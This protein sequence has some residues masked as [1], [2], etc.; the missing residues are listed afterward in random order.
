[1]S[2]PLSQDSLRLLSQVLTFRDHLPAV[3]TDDML[4]MRLLRLEREIR[5]VLVER[6]LVRRQLFLAGKREAALVR[7]L[8]AVRSAPTLL[9][10]NDSAAGC[11][12]AWTTGTLLVGEN[13]KGGR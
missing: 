13:G 11:I 7:G 6:D 9:A 10:A 1:V 3:K 8:Q 4:N 12:H 5:E 2:A